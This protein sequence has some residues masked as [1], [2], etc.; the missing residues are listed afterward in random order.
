MV[1]HIF[2][3]CACMVPKLNVKQSH[4]SATIVF[5]NSVIGAFYEREIRKPRLSSRIWAKMRF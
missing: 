4:S 2:T 3:S 5:R 1:L